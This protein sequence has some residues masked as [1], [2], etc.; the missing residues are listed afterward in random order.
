MTHLPELIE[1][2]IFGY[3]FYSKDKSFKVG[4]Y[5]DREECQADYNK[6]IKTG[7]ISSDEKKDAKAKC[8]EC[9]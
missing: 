6:Y 4:P 1:I 5:R 3:Y 2:T 8:S 7:R 9:E